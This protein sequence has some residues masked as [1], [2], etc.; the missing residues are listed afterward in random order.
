MLRVDPGGVLRPAERGQHAHEIGGD[1]RMAG[2]QPERLAVLRLRGAPVAVD[3]GGNGEPVGGPRCR[4]QGR[5]GVQRIAEMPARR[6]GRAGGE[7]RPPGAEQGP[8]PCCGRVAGQRGGEREMAVGGSEVA[9]AERDVA[10][11][12]PRFRGVGEA[13]GEGH[14]E[15]V[16][17]RRLAGG[18]RCVGD[19]EIAAERLRLARG[20]VAHG[21]ARARGDRYDD[22]GCPRGAQASH[23]AVG[24]RDRAVGTQVSIESL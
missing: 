15:P 13:P 10:E 14:I 16:G 5:P 6:I 9:D 8:C 1:P 18:Q 2:R 21:S 20:L 7:R 22:R 4:R 11:A 17:D 3:R 23:P 19:R 12:E 24:A